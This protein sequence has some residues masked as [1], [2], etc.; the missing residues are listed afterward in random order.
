MHASLSVPYTASFSF[1]ARNS[2]RCVLARLISHVG[3]FQA[4]LCLLPSSLNRVE[5]LIAAS[6]ELFIRVHAD[7][8]VKIYTHMCVPHQS[9]HVSPC[10]IPYL[11]GPIYHD[12]CICITAL[13]EGTHVFLKCKSFPVGE[14][15]AA[16]EA[17]SPLAHF[18][19]KPLESVACQ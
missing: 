9:I 6:I 5:Q 7:I 2:F 18:D 8:C 1:Y 17:A 14:Y 4:H 13:E 10:V 12:M 19:A 16:L 11:L 3:F 15:Y